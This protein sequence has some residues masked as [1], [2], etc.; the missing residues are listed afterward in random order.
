VPGKEAELMT[1]VIVSEDCGNSPK[2]L[3]IQALTIAFAKGDSKFILRNVTDDIRWNIIGDPL[4]E[5]KDRF[6]EALNEIRKGDVEVLTIRHIATHGKA[7]AVDGTRRMEN[8]KLRAFC[9][10]YEFSNSKGSAVKEITSYII[11]IK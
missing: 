4:I 10:V 11:D 7:G 3:F 5:G 8:G 6:A 9:D 2:N 1:K